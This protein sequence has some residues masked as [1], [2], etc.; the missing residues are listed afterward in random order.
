MVPSLFEPLMFYCK[1]TKSWV[2]HVQI[3]QAESNLCTAV[4]PQSYKS[5]FMLNSAE[6]KIINAHKYKNLR[7]FSTILGSDKL[8]MLFFLFINVKMPTTVGILTFM[9]R[10]NFMQKKK[11]CNLGAW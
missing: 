9:S 6:H 10:K 7:K 2:R 1:L 8:I 4:W 5:F 3:I 11:F